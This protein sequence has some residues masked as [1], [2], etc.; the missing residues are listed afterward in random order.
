MGKYAF[1][2]ININVTVIPPI[3]ITVSLSRDYISHWHCEHFIYAGKESVG[4]YI[5]R[6]TDCGYFRILSKKRFLL[7]Y[8]KSVL[9][10]VILLIYSLNSVVMPGSF[11]FIVFV[12]DGTMYKF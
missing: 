9:S 4:G 12:F 6:V 10:N 3:S 1:T 2:Y 11:R 5:F 7:R 8:E